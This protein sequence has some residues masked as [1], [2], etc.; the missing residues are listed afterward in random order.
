[1]AGALL[2]QFNEIL[3][4]VFLSTGP[5]LLVLSVISLIRTR[6]FLRRCEEV[7][8]EVVR[9]EQSTDRDRYGYTY[10]PVFSFTT[11]DGRTYT[12]TSDVSSN[13]PGFSVGEAVR[14]RYDPVNPQDARIHS[15]FQTWGA[16]I[17]SG[18]VGV[19]FLGIGSKLLGFLKLAG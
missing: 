6:S 4:F 12:V 3:G 17:I 8:G 7:N 11:G 2:D 14:V 15:F 18:A 13:P 5:C 19:A 1:M 10:A 16:A 9:L